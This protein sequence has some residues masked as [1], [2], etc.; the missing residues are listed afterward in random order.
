[1]AAY[2]RVYDMSLWAWWEVVA[3]RHRVHDYACCHLQTDYL[4]S[5]ISSKWRSQGVAVAAVAPLR[6]TGQCRFTLF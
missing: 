3:A 6:R 2:H 5:G 4:E 1:M